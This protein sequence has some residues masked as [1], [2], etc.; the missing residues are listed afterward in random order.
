LAHESS[1]FFRPNLWVTTPDILT[2]YL[3]FGGPA[4]H[5]IRAA[6][7]ATASPSW[8]M[9][10]GYELCESVARPGA[11][12]HIDS[13]KYEYRPRDWAAAEKSGK[14]IAGYITKLNQIRATHPALGQ[15]RN[16]H[17]HHTDDSAILAYSKYISAEHSFTGTA[18]SILVIANVDPHAVR[19]TTV[20]LDLAKLGLP[21]D[22]EF[23]VTDLITNKTYTWS[24][25]NFVRLDAF[26]EPVHI[27][28]IGK[29]I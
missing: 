29:V 5:K 23:Q 22:V 10:A 12:E 19:E 20:H 28:Q 13:E 8:G 17:F 27:F 21:Y 6:I 11:E 2:E 25:E 3:Q 7:A 16:I 24:S 4:A 18:D 9:Y 1:D 14:S 15:L 26:D